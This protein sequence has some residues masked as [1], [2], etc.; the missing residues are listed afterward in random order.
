MVAGTSTVRVGRS[1]SMV[2][3]AVSGASSAVGLA[4]GSV[5][6]AFNLDMALSALESSGGGT[7]SLAVQ[8]V[9]KLSEE[10]DK[11]L[12]RNRGVRKTRITRNTPGRS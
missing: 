6:G 2:A 1:R 4:L 11:L 12:N 5:N 7:V 10:L 8:S 3:S 9:A